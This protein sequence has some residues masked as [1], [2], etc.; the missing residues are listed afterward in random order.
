MTVVLY[1]GD[2]TEED[3]KN[4]LSRH[5]NLRHPNIIQIFGT[6]SSAGM[7][8][9]VA[10]DDLV[11]HEQYLDIL[12]P[13][14]IMEIYTR[15]C[16]ARHKF[17]AMDYMA[18]I[19]GGTI[20]PD[21]RT[22]WIRHT[23]GEL[24]V[25][26]APNVFGGAEISSDREEAVL[27]SDQLIKV[28]DPTAEFKAIKAMRVQEFHSICDGLP[29]YVVRVPVF[30]QVPVD[31]GLVT[32]PP[33]NGF[34]EDWYHSFDLP[35]ILRCESRS[36]T[37]PAESWFSQANYMFT[38][39]GITSGHENHGV[40]GS[41][42]F[43]LEFSPQ[44]GV[45]PDGYLFLCPT[46]HFQI[47]PNS[48]QCPELPW[49]WSL[50]ETGAHP[51]SESDSLQRGFPSV[52]LHTTV[53]I[54]T[55]NARIYEALRHF[56]RG[57]GF[58]PESQEVALWLGQPLYYPC[59]QSFAYVEEHG[60]D[61]SHSGNPFTAAADAS[62]QTEVSLQDIDPSNPIQTPA[63]LIPNFLVPGA[64]LSLEDFC[65]QQELSEQ[66]L[67]R[68]K[69]N[70]FQRTNSFNFV[71][72]TDLTEMGFLKGEIAELRVAVSAWAQQPGSGECPCLQLV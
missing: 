53:D 18:S 26:L 30:G 2:N 59:A 36:S 39:L 52:E 71:S 66:I 63:M 24:C 11:H 58:D 32:Y 31:L 29:H 40:V 14:P 19:C 60:S 3:W 23:T 57:K 34:Y 47:G 67:L 5:S 21:D 42:A 7:H 16:W 8:A 55:W 35:S 28:G 69:A 27:A 70:G 20:P 56:Y 62:H 38:K 54:R 25:E 12:Q 13:S 6:A 1:Q 10:Y 68:L 48:F 51:L 49:Y 50:D 22:L 46:E 41:V 33:G 64:N 43:E 44:E 15:G 61:I 37:L 45:L 65:S 72:L 9:A 4:Y 17:D